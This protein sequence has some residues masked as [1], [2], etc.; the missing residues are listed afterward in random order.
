MC[1]NMHKWHVFCTNAQ[2]EKF[3][4]SSKVTN[5]ESHCPHVHTFALHIDAIQSYFPEYFGQDIEVFE[6]NTGYDSSLETQQLDPQQEDGQEDNEGNFDIETGL[7]TFPA[8]TTFKPKEMMDPQLIQHTKTC[9]MKAIEDSTIEL[10]PNP[11]DHNNMLKNCDCGVG[12]SNNTDYTLKDHCTLYTRIGPVCCAYFNLPCVNGNCQLEFHEVTEEQGICFSSK[13]TCAGDEIGW[14]FVQDVVSKRTSFKAYCDDMTRKYQ[15][16]NPL[17][18]GFMS[19]NTFLKWFFGWIS[20]MKID[21][22]KEIDPVCGYNPKVLGCDG[23]HIGVSIKH[24]H[25]D[26]PVTQ[27]DLDELKKAKHQRIKRL[28]IG[29]KST[30]EAICYCCNDIMGKITDEQRAKYVNPQQ[31]HLDLYQAVQMKCS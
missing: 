27:P 9:P 30:R 2:Q 10:K 5:L 31:T 22:R 4:K 3:S 1:S 8:L 20:N 11:F 13:V 29:Q 28:L 15:T 12:Y 23:T 18:T 6:G 25:L 24:L 16:N 17:S 7:W 26:K 19:I 14:D 21:F